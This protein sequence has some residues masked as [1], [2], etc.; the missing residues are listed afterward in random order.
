M[1]VIDLNG[2]VFVPVHNTVGGAVTDAT[3]FIFQQKNTQVTADYSGGDI[4]SGHI[5]G[6]F[7]NPDTAELV[8]HC[9]TQSGELKAGQAKAKFSVS[10]HGRLCIDMQWQWLNGDQTAGTSHYEE[11]TQ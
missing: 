2:R 10:E 7:L 4:E 6:R 9:L 3:K 1:S 11:I 8:Y 5:V